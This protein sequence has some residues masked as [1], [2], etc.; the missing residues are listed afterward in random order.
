MAGARERF[1][2]PGLATPESAAQQYPLS[3]FKV[4]LGQ[5][6]YWMPPHQASHKRAICFDSPCASLD[7]S[8]DNEG[9]CEGYGADARELRRRK[10]LLNDRV[11]ELKRIIGTG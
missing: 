10:Y 6:A 3:Q 5:L 2:P 9:K 1:V 11:A 4:T 7:G 8:N